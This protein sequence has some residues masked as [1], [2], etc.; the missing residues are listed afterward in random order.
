LFNEPNNP[1][2]WYIGALALLDLKKNK[3]TEFEFF[4][5]EQKEKVLKLVDDEIF[6]NRNFKLAQLADEEIIR[7]KWKEMIHSQ[8]N[9][10]TGSL[11]NQS[12]LERILIKF[13]LQ[14][15]TKSQKRF[16]LSLQ[17]RLLCTTNRA[18]AIDTIKEKLKS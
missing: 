5:V 3:R 16:L 11:L 10:T 8:M 18:V 7:G 15:L 6:K 17:N 14:K 1:E 4:Y 2:E 12:L 9:S 13:G